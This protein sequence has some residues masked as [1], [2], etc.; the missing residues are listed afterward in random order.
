MYTYQKCIQKSIMD[1]WRITDPNAI[2]YSLDLELTFSNSV[3]NH[4]IL[5]SNG[6]QKHTH[7]YTQCTELGRHRTILVVNTNILNGHNS[8]ILKNLSRSCR[9]NN[10]IVVQTSIK[11]VGRQYP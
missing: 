7:T 2:E 3:F 9:Q 4:N 1:P 6:S 5:D 8:I 11:R 10:I